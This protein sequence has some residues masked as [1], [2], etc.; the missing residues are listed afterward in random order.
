M[1]DSFFM[2][3]VTRRGPGASAAEASELRLTLGFCGSAPVAPG[4]LPRFFPIRSPSLQSWQRHP[5]VG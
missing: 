1:T 5:E 3:L 4:T 2:S